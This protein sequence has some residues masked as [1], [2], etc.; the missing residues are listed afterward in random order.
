MEWAAGIGLL[1]LGELH[2]VQLDPVLYPELHALYPQQHGEAV[3][4]T[5]APAPLVTFR[6]LV[7]QAVACTEGEVVV[8]AQPGARGGV[9]LTRRNRPLASCDLGS[10]S[11]AQGTLDP[12]LCLD[13]LYSLFPPRPD[14][15]AESGLTQLQILVI[16]PTGVRYGRRAA[17]LCNSGGL[18]ATGADSCGLVL[19]SGL[20][21]C[22][23]LVWCSGRGPH[24]A[25]RAPW[26][27]GAVKVR[28]WADPHT[29]VISP[30][31]PPPPRG[32]HEAGP[33][34]DLLCNSEALRAQL[35][36]TLAR[37]EHYRR[38][39]CRLDATLHTELRLYSKPPSGEAWG[40]QP[41]MRGSGGLQNV[42]CMRRPQSGTDM[43]SLD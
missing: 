3:A 5:P 31:T 1:L 16:E 36:A 18:V 34:L 25:S 27:N 38:A 19:C 40:A 32:R 21:W 7:D 12:L 22:S 14:F 9:I 8:L 24:P 6:A 28:G 35:P 4:T 41:T 15:G 2:M 33:L 23:R 30:I 42:G 17:V 39:L 26:G 11:M 43:T 37:Y 13:P 20:M 10:I 29:R